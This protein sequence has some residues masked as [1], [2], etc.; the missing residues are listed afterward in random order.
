MFLTTFP[1]ARFI[2]VL[3][4]V[5]LLP[6]PQVYYLPASAVKQQLTAIT[7]TAVVGSR[8]FFDFI[9]LDAM[10]AESYNPGFETLWLVSA[11]LQLCCPS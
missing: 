2:D 4:G 1:L 5:L 3:I 7:E 11:K 6:P 8:L 9:H 10:S